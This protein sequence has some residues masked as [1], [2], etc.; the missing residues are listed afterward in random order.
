MAHL[1]ALQ[2]IIDRDLPWGCVLEDDFCYEADPDVGL[3]DIEPTLPLGFEYVHLQR[4]I[5]MN[6]RYQILGTEGLYQRIAGTP[7]FALGYVASRRLAERVLAEHA[8]CR[9]PID[10]LYNHLSYVACFYKLVKPIVGIQVGLDSVIHP[11]GPSST[12]ACAD[13]SRSRPVRRVLRT[14]PAR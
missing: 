12:G 5:G 6:P 3:A 9:M 7:L 8:I 11:P 1:R 10:H 14:L 13:L 2:R 4:D